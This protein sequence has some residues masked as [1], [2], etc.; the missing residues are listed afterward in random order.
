M[1]QSFGS[2]Q[3]RNM[4]P[5][6]EADERDFAY[7]VPVR[8]ATVAGAFARALR[9]ARRPQD[10]TP[11]PGAY[12]PPS[13]SPHKSFQRPPVRTGPVPGFNSTEA[14]SLQLE[15]RHESAPGAIYSPVETA[16]STTRSVPA[17]RALA[18]FR[19]G[20]R[21]R[22]GDTAPSSA[23]SSKQARVGSWT[24]A[25]DPDC[26]G[27]GAYSRPGEWPAPRTWPPDGRPATAFSTTE[28]RFRPTTEGG[29]RLL[30]RNRTGARGTP[31]AMHYSPMVTHTGAPYEGMRPTRPP[32][33]TLRMSAGFTG[34]P[35]W[36]SSAPKPQH[37]WAH[38]VAAHH[39]LVRAVAAAA[40]P[41]G[42]RSER[43]PSGNRHFARFE[44]RWRATAMG[45]S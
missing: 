35:R 13:L 6:V 2:T 21:A 7:F 41:A 15:P 1:I 9:F 16:M 20:G 3:S 42:S 30:A 32:A 5:G 22:W 11:G 24:Q 44:S 33:S 43:W 4:A 23:F 29:A 31:T 34:P 17:E 37:S 27:P 40:V 45:G 10:D 14:R 38:T 8:S 26:P 12:S 28:A 39:N 36:G 18:A 19:A 25:G